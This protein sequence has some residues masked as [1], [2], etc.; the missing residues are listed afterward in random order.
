MSMLGGAPVSAYVIAA[1]D[2]EL[3]AIDH[4]AMWELINSSHAAAH[5]MLN[6]LT[7]RIRNTNQIVAENLGQ[8][9]GFSA[10]ENPCC[11]P[12]FSAT[13]WLVLRI[14]L[15]SMFSM[16]CA[17]AWDLLI[18]SHMAAWSIASSSQS[19]AAMT[20]AETGAPPSMDISPT[21][22]PSPRMAIGS[23]SDSFDWMSRR[24]ERIM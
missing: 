5:N 12:R 10:P 13:I 9:Q 4:A 18:N 6:I 16:L 7:S 3:L 23:T 17:A 24:P 15:V 19:V 14:R 8:Q 21:H 22:S 20:Y 2:C 1:T 11:C